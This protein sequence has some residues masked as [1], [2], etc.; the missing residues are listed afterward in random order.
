MVDLPS[1]D[2]WAR[3]CLPLTVVDDTGP[4]LLDFTFNGWGMKFAADQDNQLGR[5]L[6]AAGCFGSTPLSTRAMK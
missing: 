3:D 1:N 4:L 5:R 2:T 6:Q